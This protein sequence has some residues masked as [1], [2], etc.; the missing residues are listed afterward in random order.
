MPSLIDLV[1][2]S[3]PQQMVVDALA[4]EVLRMWGYMHNTRDRRSCHHHEDADAKW[5][6]QLT[7]SG[8][9]RL[10]RRLL[11]HRRRHAPSS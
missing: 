3:S 8:P 7:S 2:A 4:E 1:R 5:I 10:A 11:E 9:S 6:R